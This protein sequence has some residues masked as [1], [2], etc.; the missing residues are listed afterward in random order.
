VKA[1]R[2]VLRRLLY[3]WIWIHGYERS[4]AERAKVEDELLRAARG[5]D[6]MPDAAKL[7]EWSQRLGVPAEWRTR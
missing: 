5:A 7:R 2:A 6:P 3:R 4:L 1:V